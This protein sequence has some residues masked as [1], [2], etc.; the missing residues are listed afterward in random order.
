[1]QT[2]VLTCI[3]VGLFFNKLLLKCDCVCGMLMWGEDGGQEQREGGRQGGEE[4]ERE[5]QRSIH[6]IRQWLSTYFSET[7]FPSDSRAH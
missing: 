1:M 4:R 7:G 3:I 5:C 6:V 2:Q